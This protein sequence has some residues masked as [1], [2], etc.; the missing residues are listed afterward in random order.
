MK[1]VPKIL[2][3][4]LLSLACLVPCLFPV[5]RLPRPSRITHFGY[6]SYITEANDQETQ[7]LSQT[8]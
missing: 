5:R 4:V 3:I 1:S 2:I 6:V 8:T 7:N